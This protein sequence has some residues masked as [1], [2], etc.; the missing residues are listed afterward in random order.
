MRLVNIIGGGLRALLDKQRAER[1][2]DEELRSY[3]ESAVEQKMRAGASREEAVRETRIEMGAMEALKEQVREVGWET[4]MES[5]IQDVRYGLRML[6][7]NPSFAGVAVLALALG[8][9]ANAAMF[10]V[11]EAVLLRPLPYRH[12]GEIVRVASTWDRNGTLTSYSSSPPDFFDWRDQN[13]SFSSMFAYYMG[14][15]ALTGHGEAKRV[16]AVMATAQVFS[17]LQAEPLFVR[18]CST[19]E[20]RK[21]ANHVVLLSHG[22]WQSAFGASPDALGKTIQLDSEPYTIIG[23]MPA[24]FRFPLAG[25]DAFVPIGFDDKVMTQRGAHYLA[26][27]GR[28]KSGVTLAQDNGDLSAIMA[29]LRK[30]Y[31]D[32]DG[33]WG[34]RA[35]LWSVA[36]VGDIRPALL[37][38]LGAVG[39]VALIA[40]ANISNLLLA[41]AT[42]RQRELAMRRALGAGRSR[43]VRQMLTE[44]LLLA[45]LA[46]AASLL[47]AHWALV[48]IV[49]FGPAD[50]PRLA[51]VGL[52][53][54]VLAFT[55][56]VSIACAMLF[57]L[58]PALRSSKLDASGLLR[59]SVSPSREA[60]RV[61]G[62]LLV[63]EVAL[64]MM[65]LAGA[66]LLVRSF[67]GLSALSPG[68]D[69]KD[70][71]TMS[72]AVPDAHY[73]N[74]AALQ[75]YWDRALTE[76]RSLPGV[77][78]VAAVTPLPL[79]GDDFSS[80]FS[81]AGRSVPEKDEPSAE[82]RTAT[83]DYFRTLAI[84]LRKGRAFT[85]A[86]RLGAA[87]VLLISETAAR[88]FFPEGD[89][90][91]Q[92]VKFGARGG[93]E[94]NEGEIVGVVGDVRH[95][96]VDA[97]I[98]PIFYV[99]LA[100]SGLDAVAVVMRTAASAAALTQPAR[101]A[102]Q[103]IDRDALVGEPVPMETF[104][105]ASLGQRRFYMMLLGGFAALALVLAAVGLYGVISYSVAQRTQEVGIRVALGASGSEVVAMVMRQG[106]K[107]AAAGLAIG[108]VLAL[109]LKSVLRGFLVGVSTTD[110]AT[111]AITA[112]LLFLVAVLASYVPAR[113]AARVDP[114]VALRFD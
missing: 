55:M 42:V 83:P 16:H 78:S 87:R 108:L 77:V 7:K 57:A 33:K 102:V 63:G 66:G 56:S 99:P 51:S 103:A 64:S 88:M 65:L 91:R 97:P 29:Q 89:A 30:L 112:L 38:L 81:I 9:G 50:I 109:L 40:C 2:M 19:D 12:A 84:P 45:L 73:K 72:V 3:M 86:D 62:V 69:P 101:K 95:F 36:L 20:N 1:E 8:I 105:S 70:V 10:S 34:V 80:S 47:L 90:I 11:I 26:V 46:G 82:L 71:W 31:P 67:I 58:I 17:T 32:K 59:T 6:R 52:N 98:P 21:C 5:L 49:R 111:L 4:R 114:M 54:S 43:L 39:L 13:R 107:L 61:R 35:Q 76:L 100:Q 44:G 14:E 96:G 85:E 27:L 53:G 68:F 15:F 48:A 37:V 75:T 18:E 110:P 79:S 113:R 41:R 104:V 92:K 74:S 22:F 93:Y 24:D 60:G 25:S 106:L 94:K 23:V 28:L